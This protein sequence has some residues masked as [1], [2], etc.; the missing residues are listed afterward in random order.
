[1]LAYP[2]VNDPDPHGQA[3][4]MLC[5]CMLMLLVEQGH[6]PR[7]RVLDAIAEVIDVKQEIA[8]RSESVVVSMRSIGLLRAVAQSLSATTAT[9]SPPS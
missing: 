7:D 1:M 2:M 6:L 9:T 4:L 3:A 5:E 8:G